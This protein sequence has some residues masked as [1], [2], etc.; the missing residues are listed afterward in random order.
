MRWSFQTFFSPVTVRVE[1]NKLE[2]QPTVSASRAP[3]KFCP[4]VIV[5]DTVY[6]A[7][8]GAMGKVRAVKPSAA[9]IKKIQNSLAQKK[10]DM[11]TLENIL[12]SY[13]IAKE[14]SMYTVQYVPMLETD[15]QDTFIV[16]LEV[17]DGKIKTVNERRQ[18]HTV[19]L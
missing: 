13:P 14:Y 3:P 9:D 7:S 12:K 4:P 18:T 1:E 16:S 2:M 8:W 10:L 6:Y 11:F 15:V 19:D 17:A 5:D